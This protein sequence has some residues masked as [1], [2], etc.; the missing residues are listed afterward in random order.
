MAEVL[1]LSGGIDSIA[2]AAWRHPSHCLTLDYGQ[3]PALGEIAAA[4]EVCKA[5]GL[6][7]NILRVSIDTLGCGSLAGEPPSKVSKNPEFWPFRNQF[8]VTIGAMFAIKNGLS[9]V[10]I[11]TVATDNRHADGSASF[12]KQLRRLLADQEGRIELEAP[13]L[14]MSSAELISRSGVSPGI[15]GWAHSCHTAAIAC[16]RCAGCQKH[17]EVMA[18]IGWER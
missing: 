7:H 6:K 11:G 3:R 5:L 17:T 16:G 1:L 9:S 14:G 8:L 12:V 18:A 4:S 13:A 10:V 15:L 2:I